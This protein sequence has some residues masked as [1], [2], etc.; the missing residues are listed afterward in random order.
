MYAII[1]KT[2]LDKNDVLSHCRTDILS[3]IF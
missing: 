1:H 3:I 2:I